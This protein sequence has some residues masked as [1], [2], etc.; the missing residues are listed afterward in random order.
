MKYKALAVSVLVMIALFCGVIYLKNNG[1]S[2]FIGASAECKD[3]TYSAS[4]TRRG[5]CSGHGGVKRWIYEND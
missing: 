2:R 4:K 3:G 5:T 1:E